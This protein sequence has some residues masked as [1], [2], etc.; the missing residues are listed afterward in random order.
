MHFILTG[1]NVIRDG[2][3][4]AEGVGVRGLKFTGGNDDLLCTQAGMRKEESAGPV[5]FGACDGEVDGCASLG[6][7]GVDGAKVR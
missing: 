5:E 6:S 2:E 4:E 1:W 3:A 7:N